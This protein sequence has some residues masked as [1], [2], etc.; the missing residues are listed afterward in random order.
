MP[1]RYPAS[2]L[3]VPAL[4]YLHRG[5]PLRHYK[6]LYL[7]NY[8]EA[9]LR[10]TLE[11]VYAQDDWKMTPNLTLNLG[12]RWEYGSPYSE[13]NNYISNW[14]PVPDRL[15]AFSRSD[16]RKR[17]Y[18]RSPAPAPTATRSSIPTFLTSPP[19]L[20][21]PLQPTAN[22]GPSVADSAPAMFTTPALAPAI[23]RQSTLPRRSLPPS[24][25][26]RLPRQII[27]LHPCPPRS[28]PRE[29]PR[30]AATPLPNRASRPASSPVSTPPPITSPGCPRTRPIVM[31]K[32]T[33]LSVQ[34]QM[35]K[36][37][38]VDMAYVGNHGRQAAGLYQRQSAQHQRPA[39][40][41][42]PMQLALRYY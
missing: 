29:K 42:A 17:H 14:D 21:S 34:R 26:S 10:Q 18:A 41:P 11:T 33:T 35:T 13:Q 36:N 2:A 22:I 3:S 7:A 38:L 20:A 23:S 4:P 32:T 30:R 8:F 6:H 15:Y 12:L 5:L 39:L 1:R 16:S 27:A 37:S 9:H 40:T 31:L 25:R 24:A 19:A 28:S